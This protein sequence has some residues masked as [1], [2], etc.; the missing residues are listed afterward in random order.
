MNLYTHYREVPA[1]HPPCVY[2]LVDPRAPHAPRY[3][4]S[5]RALRDRLKGHH[6]AF[7]AARNE[8]FDAWLKELLSQGVQ[9]ALRVVAVYETEAEC[10]SAEWKIAARWR[11]RGIQLTSTHVPPVCDT[12]LYYAGQGWRGAWAEMRRLRAA[13]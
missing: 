8:T 5:S 3:V 11:R 1:V 13:A 10:R 4:G 9:P 6:K 12:T 7:S 2:V